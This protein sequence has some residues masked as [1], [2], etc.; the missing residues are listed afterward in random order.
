MRVFPTLLLALVTATASHAA[1]P[2]R[3]EGRVAVVWEPD[4]RMMTLLEPFAYID[5]SGDRWDAPV[6]SHTDGASIPRIAWTAVGGP[7]EDKYREA[8]VI[9]DVACQDRKRPWRRVHKTFYEGMITRGVGTVRAKTMYAAVYHFGPRWSSVVALENVPAPEVGALVA[10]AKAEI[11]AAQND[12]SVEI[13]PRPRSMGALV[14]GE[15]RRADVVVRATAQPPTLSEAEFD[16]L[17]GVIEQRELD[18]TGPMSLAE[19]QEFGATP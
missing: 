19:I 4:G 3:F 2:G 6:G 16:R 8:A 13:R 17:R 11:G 1:D 14:R 18:G 9:H 12:V 5:S 7:F 15:P 10:A